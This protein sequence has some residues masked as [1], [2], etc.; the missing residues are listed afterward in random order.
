MS[1]ENNFTRGQQGL[2][3]VIV[4]L[5]G[6][7]IGMIAGICLLSLFLAI[8]MVLTSPSE[9]IRGHALQL[10]VVLV[11]LGSAVIAGMAMRRTSTQAIDNLVTGFLEKT[12]MERMKIHCGQDAILGME[13]YPFSKVILSRTGRNSSYVIYNLVMRQGGD[14]VKVGFKCN[15][16]NFE[17][18]ASLPIERGDW[19][20]NGDISVEEAVLVNEN[21]VEALRHKVLRFF[22]GVLQGSMSEGYEIYVKFR[23]APVSEDGWIMDIS[24]RQKLRENFLSSPFLKRYFAEDAAIAVGV[25]YREWLAMKNG[26]MNQSGADFE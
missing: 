21:M 1:S 19:V 13:A 18:F 10:L 2:K 5:P 22:P 17:I 16:F 4:T 25:L 14:V 6:W 23:D 12:I 7:G 8:A 3:D 24:F 20:K 9:N 26:V 15:V 11:P